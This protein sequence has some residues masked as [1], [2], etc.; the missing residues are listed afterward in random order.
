MS[1]FVVAEFNTKDAASRD[2]Y[3]A[4][5]APIIADFGG[6]FA[7]KGPWQSLFG[8]KGYEAGGLIEFPDREAALAWYNSPAYQALID[9]R[10]TG[11]DCRFRLIG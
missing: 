7:A 2:K 11:I 6:K 8:Q 10:T 3:S 5:A 1:V 4:A 9:L